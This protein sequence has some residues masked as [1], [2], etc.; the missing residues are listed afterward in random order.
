MIGVIVPAHDEAAAIAACLR[1]L[2][3]ASRHAGLAGEAVRI[4]VALDRC[5]DGTGRIARRLG[6]QTLALRHGNV[7]LA[8]DA[9]A[10]AA[11]AQGARWIASTD[12]DSQVPPDW[13]SAQLAMAADAFCGTVTVADWADYPP[14]VRA[15]FL[16]R[17][18]R[19]DGHP[20]VHGANLG[21]RADWYLRVGGFPPLPAHEAR[22]F[23]QALERAGAR[24]ARRARPA[25]VT[26]AR[27]DPRARNGFGDYLQ[28][29]E[30]TLAPVLGASVPTG[31]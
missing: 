9:A 17:E 27:R 26:S 6:A 16:A 19:A 30:R 12:A 22:L 8:R 4:I 14:D 5:A 29:L 24:I 1:S 20:H 2:W 18:S 15:G 23:V 25:V 10:Q 3:R 31:R 11:L 13:L 28:Q 7:G 21:V